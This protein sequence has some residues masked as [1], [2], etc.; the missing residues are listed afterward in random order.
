LPKTLP[1]FGLK[2]EAKTAK[3]VEARW[4]KITKINHEK[5]Q[6]LGI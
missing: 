1:K 5:S 2:V 6:R 4:L 3:T